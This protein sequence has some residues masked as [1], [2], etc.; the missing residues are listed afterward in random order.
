MVQPTEG[1]IAGATVAQPV[2]EI[3]QTGGS[4]DYPSG[5]EVNAPHSQISAERVQGHVEMG[6]G[7]QCFASLRP[8]APNNF[9]GKHVEL[10]EWLEAV[11]IYLALYGQ[12]D[13]NIMYM[14]VNQS[15]SA[16][17]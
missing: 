17:V 9:T 1:T 6:N 7:C 15:L 13:D 4:G 16:D 5:N 3:P 12:T 8:E 10:E 2:Y 11:Q 14:V